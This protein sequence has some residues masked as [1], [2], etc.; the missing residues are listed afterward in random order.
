VFAPISK[1][2][3]A[4]NTS[5]TRYEVERDGRKGRKKGRESK[6]S[7]ERRKAMVGFCSCKTG[8]HAIHGNNP[9]A[10][11][12]ASFQSCRFCMFSRVSCTTTK[13]AVRLIPGS[14][15]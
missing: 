3:H 12:Q 14:Y 1:H 15:F 5:K 8:T 6:M 7:G 9:G 13:Q 10:T 11:T 4:F 2:A